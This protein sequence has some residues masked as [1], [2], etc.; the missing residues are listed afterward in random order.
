MTKQVIT[1][2]QNNYLEAEDGTLTE[3]TT[4]QAKAIVGFNN[5][6]EVPLKGQVIAQ[7]K[8]FESDGGNISKIIPADN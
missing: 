7:G 4:A 5:V 6:E 1:Q 3:L 8:Y 2:G